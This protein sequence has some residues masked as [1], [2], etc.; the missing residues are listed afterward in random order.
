MLAG[1]DACPPCGRRATVPAEQLEARRQRLLDLQHE[2]VVR[3]VARAHHDVVATADAAGAGDL[4]R[5]V[6]RRVAVEHLLA[7]RADG[8]EGTSRASRASLRSASGTRRQLSARR[9]RTRPRIGTRCG[10]LVARLQRRHALGLGEHAADRAV[11]REAM[12]GV[13]R[14]LVRRRSAKTSC[15]ASRATTGRG[16]SPR[17]AR[18]VGRAALA[19]PDDEADP[20]PLQSHSHGARVVSSKSLTSKTICRRARSTRRGCAHARRRRLTRHRSSAAPSDRAPSPRRCRAR[21]TRTETTPCGRGGTA[22]LGDAALLAGLEAARSR[23]GRRF[24]DPR[25]VVD[26][27]HDV[28]QAAAVCSARVDA[29]RGAG[30]GSRWRISAVIRAPDR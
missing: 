24:V 15:S 30:G 25:V 20:R 8:R 3:P 10:E 19:R 7:A 18:P 5:D 11:A 9:R 22:A 26:A 27:A 6:V 16:P 2:R 21:R 13:A 14:Q 12:H 23:R 28:A 29:R 17:R 4:E 1:R